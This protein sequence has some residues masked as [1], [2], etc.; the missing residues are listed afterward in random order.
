MQSFK[1]WNNVCCRIQ[2]FYFLFALCTVQ[3]IW[4]Q[5]PSVVYL[6][7]KATDRIFMKLFE[8]DM[9]FIDRY[10]PYDIIHLS[11]PTC[12]S[13]YWVWQVNIV[14]WWFGI[15]TPKAQLPRTNYFNVPTIGLCLCCVTMLKWVLEC[16]WGYNSC[17]VIS[18]SLTPPWLRLCGTP[19]AIPIVSECNKNE[20]ILL[21]SHIIQF[22]WNGGQQLLSDFQSFRIRLIN[23]ISFRFSL[24]LFFIFVSTRLRLYG[25]PE[26]FTLN[27]FKV[28]YYIFGDYFT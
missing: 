16:M 11:V 27:L 2:T 1:L 9:R 7:F 18:D 8:L 17:V 23:L 26:Y 21:R 22:L 3:Q 5:R 25:V 6:V 20:W 4:V 19:Q 14:F 13:L 28:T 24:P 10:T 12:V 15:V